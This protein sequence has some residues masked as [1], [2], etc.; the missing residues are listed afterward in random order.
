MP[1]DPAVRRAHLLAQA[2]ASPDPLVADALRK[3]V[4]L[5]D[6]AASSD[7]E[8]RRLL[9]AQWARL[10]HW[11]Q[12]KHAAARAMESEIRS[13]RVPRYPAENTPEYFVQ[14]L[15]NLGVNTLST[16]TISDDLDAV[17][18]KFAKSWT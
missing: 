4:A 6:V 2:D 16:R 12:S 1:L 17:A 13:L 5:E 14:A 18:A 9:L 10:Y 7:V 3:L 8:R 15:R 11:H